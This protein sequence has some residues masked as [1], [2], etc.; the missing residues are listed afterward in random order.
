MRVA[1]PARRRLYKP[2]A[3]AARGNWRPIQARDPL[4]DLVFEGDALRIILRE[5]S[6]GCIFARKDFEMVDVTDLFAGIG[7]DQTLALQRVARRK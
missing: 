7:V 5:P 1:R 2:C 3:G 6:L 4:D